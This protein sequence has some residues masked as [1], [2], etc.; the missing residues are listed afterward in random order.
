MTTKMFFIYQSTTRA[1]IT[2]SERFIASF[3]SR[4]LADHAIKQL[5][6]HARAN[7]QTLKLRPTNVALIPGG[8]AAKYPEI[9]HTFLI[10]EVPHYT[11]K[12]GDA[13]VKV[14]AESGAWSN[15]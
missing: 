4:D 3:P 5:E 14:M 2:T 6:T 12:V 9:R 7:W 13:E 15:V 8:F 11:E 1:N 10:A